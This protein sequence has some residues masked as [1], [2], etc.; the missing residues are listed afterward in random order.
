MKGKCK[1]NQRKSELNAMFFI[2]LIAAVMFIISTYA[3]FSTQKNVSITN[4]RGTVEVAEG[5]EISL[6]AEKWYN[7]I[8]LGEEDGQ[9]SIT[10]NAYQGHHNISPSEMLPVST[11]GLVGST[12]TDLKMLRGNVTNS[13][14]L[15]K[16]AETKEN[17]EVA[18]DPQ[19]PGYFAFDIFLKN[20]SKQSSGDDILQLNYDS[21]L[22][23]MDAS[24]TATGLQNTA[25]IAFCKYAG[26]SEV[27]ASQTDILKE[28]AGTGVGAPTAYISDVA[29]WEPNADDHVDY[30]VKNNNKITW[31]AS[32]ASAYA[33]KTLDDGTKGFDTTTKMPTYALKTSAVGQTIN[34]IYMWNGTEANLAR[35]YTLQTTKTSTTDYTIKEGV[36][37]LVK[38]T[39][40]TTAFGIA[41]NKI[42]RIRVYLWLEGQDVDCINYASHGGGVKVNIGLV[43]GSVVGSTEAPG[44]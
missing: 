44:N 33:T 41:P 12:D 1:K 29:I 10:K 7:G 20:N 4:L 34:D 11:L 43:K 2:I 17:I 24:K 6:D 22:E 23:I 42:T 40:G 21:S 32:D 3:W 14:E 15:S 25:R 9:L 19:F 27:D 38:A 18:T 13:K 35:Q 39:D 8:T 30:I 28:T 36:Q 16:I 37:N 26:T 5:L 31:S